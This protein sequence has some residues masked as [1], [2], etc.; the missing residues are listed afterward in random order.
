[1]E[2][3]VSGM[4]PFDKFEFE[5]PP[6][7]IVCANASAA[8]LYNYNEQHFFTNISF[9]ADH[10]Y[11]TF[12]NNLMKRFQ[13]NNDHRVMKRHQNSLSSPIGFFSTKIE[14]YFAT[15]MANSK[16]ICWLFETPLRTAWKWQNQL[17]NGPNSDNAI[18]DVC[19]IRL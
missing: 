4:W 11:F 2:H 9:L 1:M 3:F 10:H 12:Y 18:S 15:L 5:T 16:L 17:L 13:P 6:C 8:S 19:P 7:L 14:R